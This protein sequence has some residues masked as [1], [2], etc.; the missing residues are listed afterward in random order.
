MERNDRS[1]AK[2]KE[3]FAHW[4]RQQL[5]TR[6]FDLGIRGGGQSRFA[7][8]AGIGRATISR[9]LSGQGA[10]DTAVLARLAEALH[11]SLGEVLVRAGIL[12]PSELTAINE[13]AAGTRRITP[14]QAAEE[15]GIKDPQG[16]RVFVALAQTLQR[17]PPPDD[18]ESAAES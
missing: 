16:R 11:I 17:T 3:D 7:E 15:L 18:A 2:A 12:N 10:T 14:E 1:D 9:I 5:E 6:G 8:E 13:P 4:L